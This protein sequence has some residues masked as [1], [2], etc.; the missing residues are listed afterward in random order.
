MEY[1]AAPQGPLGPSE[2]ES[3]EGKSGA[4]SARL[5]R[6]IQK[7]AIF[8]N[9]QQSTTALGVKCSQ[10]EMSA[11]SQKQIFPASFGMSAKCHKQTMVD[12]SLQEL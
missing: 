10:S 3:N 11:L 4:R 1:L 8:Q 9:T 2:P 7:N 5:N 12:I 6:P